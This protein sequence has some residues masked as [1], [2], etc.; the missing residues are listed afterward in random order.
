VVAA[1]NSAGLSAYSSSLSVT[2][3][4]NNV[5]IRVPEADEFQIVYELD[6]PDNGAFTGSTPVPYRVDET[7]SVSGSLDR[8][9]YYLELDRGLGSEW[10]YVSMDAFTYFPQFIGLPHSVNNPVKFQQIITNMSVVAGGGAELRVT[11]GEN[12]STGNIE[13]WP[14]NYNAIDGGNIPGSDDNVRDFGDGANATINSGYGSFQVHNYGAKETIFAYN[15]WG[16]SG[17]PDDLGIG[18]N[19]REASNGRTEPDWTFLSNASEY[20]LKQL[21]ILVKTLPLVPLA[22]FQAAATSDTEVELT[23]DAPDGAVSYIVWR[24]G[25]EIGTT[26]TPSFSDT[27]LQPVTAYGYQVATVY[28]NVTS[29]LSDTLNFPTPFQNVFA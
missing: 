5:Y 19:S 1:E 7:G 4:L 6:I 27:D 2:T 29:V 28:S 12:I 22:N 24:D 15:H 10:V 21:T 18:N 9:A 14:S 8:I 16:N 23:W 3:I 20:T 25:M 17:G 11:T 26:V 13:F